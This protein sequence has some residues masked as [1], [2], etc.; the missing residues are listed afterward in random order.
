MEMIGKWN[1]IL[2][3]ARSNR[4]RPALDDKS[5]TSWNSM[6]ISGLVKAYR[7]LGD[8]GYLDMALSC[9]QV[10]RNKLWSGDQVLYRSYKDGNRTIPGFHIDYALYT[11][12]CLDLYESSLDQGWLELATELTGVTVD[13]FYD[14][15]SGL[16][17]Y[18]AADTEVLI[19]HRMEI[20]DHVI[21]SSNSVMAHNLF[22]LGHLLTNG[23]YLDICSAMVGRLAQRIVQ[24]P[25][26]YAGLGRLLIK[27]QQPYYE[28]AVVGPEAAEIIRRLSAAYIPQ[29]VLAG[30]TGES[31][32]P[33]FRDRYQKD[34]TYIFVCSNNVCQLPVEDP[35]DAE[36][37]YHHQ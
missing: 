30:T 31:D 35:E 14:E 8:P 5:L 6:M 19:T 11:E 26:S 4:I 12:A 2:L 16:F 28:V 36:A 15:G 1:R 10:I 7:A 21:P 23:E 37:I 3:E 32:L 17:R 9:A 25:N 13:R 24:Y 34:K 29:V 20:Q 33:L 27:H 18:N 22:R